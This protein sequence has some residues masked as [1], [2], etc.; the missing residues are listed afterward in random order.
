MGMALSI[1]NSIVEAHGGGLRA[2]PATPHGTGFEFTLPVA[3]G[4][5]R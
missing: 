5:L 2:S 1:S 3:S 4:E